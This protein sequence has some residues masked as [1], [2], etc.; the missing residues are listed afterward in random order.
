MPAAKLTNEVLDLVLLFGRVSI[1]ARDDQLVSVFFD[2]LFQFPG[3]ILI[4][5]YGI[6]Q[7]RN[8][9]VLRACRLFAVGPRIGRILGGILTSAQDNA[10]QQEENWNSRIGQHGILLHGPETGRSV[11]VSVFT[12][13]ENLFCRLRLTVIREFESCLMPMD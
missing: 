9:H 11:T 6:G 3:E 5:R 12:K 4:E 2:H 1:P 13:S 10:T 8:R 7:Y